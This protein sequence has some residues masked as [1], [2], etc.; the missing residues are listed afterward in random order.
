MKKFL[1]I[2]ILLLSVFCVNACG[3]KLVSQNDSIQKIEE[4]ETDVNDTTIY[5]TKEVDVK[6]Q[7][8][9][10]DTALMKWLNKNITYPSLSHASIQGRVICRFVVEKDGLITNI[11]I[12]KS[13]HQSLDREVVRLVKL[14]PKWSPAIK[15]K[16]IVRCYFIL[17]V[18]FVLRN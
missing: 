7:F 6:P 17:P 8:I 9:G 15:D 1:L 14:M 3:Q 11:E 10:G 18:S 4:Y 13:V 5:T 12:T 16:K 2:N